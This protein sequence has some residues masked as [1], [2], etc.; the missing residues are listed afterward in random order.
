MQ[1][2]FIP[3]RRADGAYLRVT[4]AFIETQIR[5]MIYGHLLEATSSNLLNGTDNSSHINAPIDNNDDSNSISNYS[6]SNNSEN[7]R[8]NEEDDISKQEENDND[9]EPDTE[10]EDGKNS[11]FKSVSKDTNYNSFLESTSSE[12]SQSPESHSPLTSLI[13][14]EEREKKQEEEEEEDE[15]YSQISNNTDS[16]DDFCKANRLLSQRIAQLPISLPV[17]HFLVYFRKEV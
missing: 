12:G 16:L 2:L 10:N 17:K 4:D 8:S 6:D 15:K 13:I 3:S 14:E 9:S 5:M 1:R 7:E 11:Y